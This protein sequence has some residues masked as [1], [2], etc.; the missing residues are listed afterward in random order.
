MLL[1]DRSSCYSRKYTKL[2]TNSGFLARN[3]SPQRKVSTEGK[4][5]IVFLIKNFMALKKTRIFALRAYK[6][7]LNLQSQKLKSHLPTI[8]QH[9][10]L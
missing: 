9:D 8:L 5:F 10:L 2:S 4:S 3:T 1:R 7:A 6:P